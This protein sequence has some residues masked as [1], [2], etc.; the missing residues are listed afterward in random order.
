LLD[1][2]QALVAHTR[3]APGVPVGLSPRAAIGLLRAARAWALIEG[4]DAVIPEH[5]QA[6]FAAVV[7]HRLQRGTAGESAA[8]LLEAVPIP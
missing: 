8:R 6:V 5:V 7:E 1:Y 3:H 4:R 2:V